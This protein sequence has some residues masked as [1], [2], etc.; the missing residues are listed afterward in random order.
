MIYFIYGAKPTWG[1]IKGLYE[2]EAGH[3][4]WREEISEVS[5]MSSAMLIS[6]W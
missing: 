6:S 5:K 4:R 3:R 1:Q 2:F